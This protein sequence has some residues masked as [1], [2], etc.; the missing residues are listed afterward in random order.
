[1][2]SAVNL[3]VLI[4]TTA[5]DI[6]ILFLFLD[7]IRIDDNNENNL[8]HQHVNKHIATTVTFVRFCNKITRNIAAKNNRVHK[9]FL[10]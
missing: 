8:R 5:D 3:K 2:V 7:E 4:T 1:M 9:L 6:F 10:C